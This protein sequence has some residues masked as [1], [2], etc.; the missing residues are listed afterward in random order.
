MITDP[1]LEARHRQAVDAAV[2]LLA[3]AA[4]PDVETATLAVRE[5]GGMLGTLI[6]M[7]REA[8]AAD[9][10]P[11][12][13]ELLEC[14][15]QALR[16]FSGAE[17]VEL[18]LRLAM[19]D[20]L[21]GIG[22]HGAAALGNAERAL[23]LAVSDGS[24]GPERGRALRLRGAVLREHGR[25]PEA[26]RDLRAALEIAEATDPESPLVGVTLL[27]LS[28]A[29]GRERDY[30]GSLRYGRRAIEL[31]SRVAPDSMLAGV[32]RHFYGV[33]LTVSGDEGAAGP[34]FEEALR[35]LRANGSPPLHTARALNTLGRYQEAIEVLGTDYADS[36]PMVVACN[37]LAEER[38]EAGDAAVARALWGRGLQ[39]VE[40]AVPLSTARP[41]LLCKLAALD[42]REGDL[43][44]AIS[45]LEAAASEAERF[46]G[47]EH[48][49]EAQ[50]MLFAELQ[51]PFQLLIA[52][53]AERDAPGDRARAYALA[54]RSRARALLDLL[55]ERGIEPVPETPAQHRLLEQERE[56]R[57][58]LG[59]PG[60]ESREIERRL[61]ALKLEIKAAFPLYA[62]QRDPDPVDLAGAQELLGERTLLLEYDASGDD[63]FVW[64]L[65]RDRF[66]MV[67][68][69][70]GEAE[71][72]DLVKRLTDLCRAAGAGIEL[73][74]ARQELSRLLLGPLP[75]SLWEG[76]DRLIVVPDGAL[77]Y[78]PFELLAIPGAGEAVADRLPVAYAPS[79]TALRDLGRRPS[80]PA[81]TREFVGFGDPAFDPAKW[82]RRLRG[83]GEEVRNIATAFGAGTADTN[84]GWASQGAYLGELATVGNVRGAAGTARYL[85]FAT[86]AV[87]DDQRPLGS[88]FVL[89]PPLPEESAADEHL[90]DILRAHEIFSLR[91]CADVAVCSACQ[92]GLGELRAGEG[93][94]GLS[95]AF[96]FAGAPSLLVS[97]WPV[98]D[99]ATSHLMQSFYVH[100]RAGA[101]VA[102]A[103]W[104]ARRETRDKGWTN[105][106]DWAGFLVVGQGWQ[107]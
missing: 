57:A 25:L 101:A 55:A 92:T 40:A 13:R 10:L 15:L 71:I 28:R 23:G 87:I 12:A 1:E 17:Q 32:A 27:D 35:I 19:G 8:E 78:L 37:N 34:H 11:V 69:E 85:H 67:A 21:I 4:A 103:L 29:L 18:S 65:R 106:R 60:E 54:E 24:P 64:G 7:A 66:E 82:G 73:E 26:L 100:L 98:D 51:N 77:F 107:G 46:R 22:D 95:R 83:S 43:S 5:L 105:P 86:H 89:A 80:R 96:F 36:L 3:R 88:G 30:A 94:V 16:R 75:R 44:A 99:Q 56:L 62:E 58:M 50:E 52:V 9:N 93:M 72:G 76:V 90:G 48:G 104:R 79:A 39:A 45:L 38:L 63:A 84:Q 42:R 97:L 41:A 102:E 81:P 70:A 2:D 49:D 33:A 53:L 61:E 59:T 47:A 74:L 91:L 20:L 68:I 14:A 31:F 6:E